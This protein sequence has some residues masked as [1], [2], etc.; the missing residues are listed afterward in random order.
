M[1]RPHSPQMSL[2]QPHFWMNKRLRRELE[3][4]WAHVFRHKVFPRIPE[5][6]FAD[7]Y[8]EG[9]GAPNFPVRLLVTLS[10]LKELL[11]LRDVDLIANFHFN[12]LFHYALWIAPGEYTLSLRTLY[13]FRARITGHEGM[14]RVFEEITDAMLAELGLDPSFQRI[15][16]TQVT[17]NM[18][19]LNRLTLFARTIEVFLREVERRCPG[20][21]REVAE[22]IRGRYL[23]RSGYFGDPRQAGEARRRLEQAAEDVATLVAQ[24]DGV[25]P[26]C[27][28]RTYALLVRL[29]TEQCR[30]EPPSSDEGKEGGA[31]SQRIVV[32]RD[33]K[34]IASDSLQ[35]PS[36]P[37]AT[38]NRHKGK[39]Y[40]VQVMETCTETNPVQL[41]TAVKVQGANEGDG[42]ALMPMLDA[43][44]Q[45]GWGPERVLGDTHYGGTERLLAAAERRVDLLAP[46]PGTVDPADLTLMDFGIDSDTLQILSCPEG[47]AVERRRSHAEGKGETVW[48]SAEACKACEQRESCPAGRHQGRLRVT[49]EALLLAWNRARETTE[50]FRDVYRLRSGIEGTMSELKRA[51]GMDRI[52]TRGRARVTWVVFCKALACNIKRVARWWRTEVLGAG[53]PGWLAAARA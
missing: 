43:L 32:L 29:F 2:F 27:S 1:Y 17:S 15:D 18:A 33:P 8:S 47:H 4:S 10:V 51:H 26:V 16:A 12:A 13:N 14:A 3:S 42:N 24:F 45:R 37:D 23:D 20:R 19:N 50:A 28:L 5:D 39:G 22:E 9:R 30:V 52:W 6:V 25:E 38:Y 31:P 36:D 53:Q 34:E 46:T 35:N 41:V 7:L 44:E 48:F 49:P 11:G 40:T 21:A